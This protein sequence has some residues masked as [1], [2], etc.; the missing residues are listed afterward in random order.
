[1]LPLFTRAAEWHAIYV[2]HRHEKTIA[3]HLEQAGFEVFLPLSREMRQWS[4]RRKQI[5]LPLFPCYVF[6][7]GGLDRRLAILNTPGVFSLVTCNGKAAVIPAAELEP[8]RRVVASSAAVAPYPFLHA[9]ERI[10]VYKGPL[11]GIEGI[12]ARVK[13]PIRKDSIGKESAHKDSMRI[14]LSVQTLSRSIAV[15]IETSLVERV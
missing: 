12:V 5:S 10:R 3:Q 6:F 14:V 15:E 8:I 13:D 7:S 11:A 1:M 9:G 2:R 4:D